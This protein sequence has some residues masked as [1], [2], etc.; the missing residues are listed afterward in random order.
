[1]HR[2]LYGAV[3]AALK[4]LLDAG[5]ILPGAGPE[6]IV[7]SEFGIVQWQSRIWLRLATLA[8]GHMVQFQ[9]SRDAAV[10]V[11]MHCKTKQASLR[12]SF[13]VR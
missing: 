5:Q 2:L 13:I 1:M 8:F 4:R 6:Q 12:S 9:L 11:C 7:K 10:I 3:I